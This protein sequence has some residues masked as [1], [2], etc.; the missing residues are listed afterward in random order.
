MKLF[1][2]SSWRTV[3]FPFTPV[4]PRLVLYAAVLFVLLSSSSCPMYGLHAAGL[5][6]AF[7]HLP[8]YPAA[9]DVSPNLEAAVFMP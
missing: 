4:C 3:V 5:I 8:S 7:C 2:C 1:C 6:N 9:D